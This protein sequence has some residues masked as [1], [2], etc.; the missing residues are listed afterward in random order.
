[1]NL[2]ITFDN[3]DK[4]KKAFLNLRKYILLSIDEIIEELGYNPNSLDDCAKFLVNR[5][6]QTQ[7]KKGAT[8]KKAYGLIYSNP[9]LDDLKIREIIH[10]CSGIEPISDVYFLTEKGKKEDYYELFDG[11]IFYPILRKVHIIDC[12][13]YPAEIALDEINRNYFFD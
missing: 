13:A 1:M 7:I 4:V 2:Y 3:K 9:D 12:K 11:V 10:F 5:E 6:I 8:R